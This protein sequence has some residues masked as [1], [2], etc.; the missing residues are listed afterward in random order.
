MRL[1]E[2]IDEN[3]YK[4]L[5]YVKEGTHLNGN[6]PVGIGADP[7]DINRLDWEQ[8]KR[9]IHNQMVEQRLLTWD[10]IQK[11]QNALAG[12]VLGV[13]RKQIVA[14]YRSINDGE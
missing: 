10:D 5:A 13:V 7:P 6:A 4:H 3:G 14:L 8:I 12:I 1:A 11:H 2:W 9:E